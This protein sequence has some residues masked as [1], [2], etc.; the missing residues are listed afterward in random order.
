ML[1]IV[2]YTFQNIVLQGNKGER[3]I[4]GEPGKSGQKVRIQYHVTFFYH[5]PIIVVNDWKSKRAKL[6]QHWTIVG[7]CELMYAERGR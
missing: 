1:Y 5:V 7:N 6:V 3:G 4:P 2:N